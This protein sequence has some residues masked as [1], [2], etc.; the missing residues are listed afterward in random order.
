MGTKQE[1]QDGVVFGGSGGKEVQ[2]SFSGRRKEWKN[3]TGIWRER[4]VPVVS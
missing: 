4:I 3:A 2:A 1:D